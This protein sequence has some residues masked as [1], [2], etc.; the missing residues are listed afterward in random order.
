MINL[1]KDGIPEDESYDEI[2]EWTEDEEEAFML[3]M[4]NSEVES[5]PEE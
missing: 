3:M 2:L 1:S 4:E 5:K